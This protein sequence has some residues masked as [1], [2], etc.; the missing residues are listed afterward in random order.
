MGVDKIK[1]AQRE[2]FSLIEVLLV[3][4]LTSIIVLSFTFIIFNCTKLYKKEMANTEQI[5]KSILLNSWLSDKIECSAD[6][7]ISEGD[8]KLSWLDEDSEYI[9]KLITYDSQGE[10]AVGIDKYSLKN[11]VLQYIYKEPIMNGVVDITVEEV[12]NEKNQ[13]Y[14]FR[15]FLQFQNSTKYFVSMIY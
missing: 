8:E 14:L 2:G 6:A 15:L 3:L 9:Y 4:S 10:P 5:Q 1:R 12:F 7:F 13:N 11:N